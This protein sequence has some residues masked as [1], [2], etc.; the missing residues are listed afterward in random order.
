[1]CPVVL[2]ELQNGIVIVGARR[3]RPNLA[4]DL[5][6]HRDVQAVAGKKVSVRISAVGS[7]VVGVVFVKPKEAVVVDPDAG[8]LRR[9]KR[10]HE[11]VTLHLH[12]AHLGGPGGG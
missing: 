7:L 5:S 4:A 2:G 1:M 6:S 9:S 11:M 3:S 8:H 10:W 12:A